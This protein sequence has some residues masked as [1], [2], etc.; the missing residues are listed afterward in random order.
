MQTTVS[1]KFSDLSANSLLQPALRY[2]AR[3]GIRVE[4]LKR[5]CVGRLGQDDLEELQQERQMALSDAAA[6]RRKLRDHQQVASLAL[7][8]R[9]VTVATAG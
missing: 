5:C 1:I 4:G 8:G 6:A 3:H 7:Q 2:L 9:D